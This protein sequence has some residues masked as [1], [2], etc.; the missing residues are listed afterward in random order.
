MSS[1]HGEYG[2]SATSSPRMWWQSPSLGNA[3][4]SPSSVPSSSSSSALSVSVS[5]SDSVPPSSPASRSEPVDEYD[6][7]NKEEEE[8]AFVHPWSRYFE[9]QTTTPVECMKQCRDVIRA[10]HNMR[11]QGRTEP[12]P[13]GQGALQRLTTLFQTKFLDWCYLPPGAHSET[14]LVDLMMVA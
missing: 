11:F 6:E 7:E 4:C 13:H 14:S 12:L 1:E 9:L 5:V 8:E 10:I 2:S 3:S